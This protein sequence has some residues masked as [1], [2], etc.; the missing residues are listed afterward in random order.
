MTD[1][2][3]APAFEFEAVAVPQRTHVGRPAAPN[4]FLDVVK[5]L[6]PDS[7]EAGQAQAFVLKAASKEALEG[8]VNS[9][10]RKLGDAGTKNGVTVGIDVA[11]AKDGKSIQVT[12]W[13]RPR[14]QRKA[15]DGEAA[16][17]ATA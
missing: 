11:V 8:E 7:R 14:I 16:P 10:R 17:A 1:T 5:A 2:A 12:F 6:G 4:P 9:A 3:T 13:T 15:K